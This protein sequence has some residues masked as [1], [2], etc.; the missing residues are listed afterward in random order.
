MVTR[1]PLLTK[2][3]IVYRLRLDPIGSARRT[4]RTIRMLVTAVEKS[5]QGKVYIVGHSGDY[6][7]HLVDQ[8]KQMCFLAGLDPENIQGMD[9]H[10]L[11]YNSFCGG[12]FMRGSRTPIFIDHAVIPDYEYH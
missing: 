1:K 6:T 5:Q 7:R 4:G 11:Q 12:F 10:S 8:A 3:D 2:D 9:I